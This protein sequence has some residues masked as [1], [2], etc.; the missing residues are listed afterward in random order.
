MAQGITFQI[1]QLGITGPLLLWFASYLDNRKQR[2]IINGQNSE[3]LPV[4]AGVPQGSILGPLLFLVFINDITENIDSDI[5]LFA[6]DTSLLEIIKNP[7]QSAITLNNDLKTIHEW[8]CQWLMIFN[9][10]KT[11]AMTFSLQPTPIPQPNILL[12]NSPVKELSQHCHLGLTFCTNMKWNL[13]ISNI[14]QRAS[15]RNN[16]LRKLK[17]R[18]PRKTLEFFFIQMIRPILEYCDVIFD[19]CGIV[20]TQKLESVQYDA[21]R[22]CLG[23]LPT[24]NRK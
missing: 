12:N 9:A 10:D 24:T 23:A 1:K 22:T 14:Y 21:A 15:Q 4:E 8:A 2:V 5:N 13:H 11:I 16:I 17:Y 19:G 18:L 7:E 20:Q 3:W 6:D